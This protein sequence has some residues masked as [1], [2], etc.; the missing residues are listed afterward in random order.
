MGEIYVPCDKSC[1]ANLNGVCCV[2]KCRGQ[3]IVLKKCNN[4][5]AEKRCKM[6]KLL[7]ETL[8]EDFEV[9]ES[10]FENLRTRKIEEE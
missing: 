2:G 5:S 3:I 10:I 1:I 8:G 9:D 4:F 6:Y 7:K